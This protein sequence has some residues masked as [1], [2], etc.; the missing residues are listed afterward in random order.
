VQNRGLGKN[1]NGKSRKTLTLYA[2][3]EAAAVIEQAQ[4]QLKLF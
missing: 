2:E 3:K 1:E 4:R